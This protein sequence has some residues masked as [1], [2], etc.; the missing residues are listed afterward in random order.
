[1]K[2]KVAGVLS[3]LVLG[4]GLSTT[5]SATLIDRGNGMIYDTD[6]NLTWLQDANYAKTSG[7]DADG[8]MNWANSMTWASNLV[9]GG[10]D[11]WRLAGITD[12]GTSG[13]NYSTNGTDCGYNV[14][15]ANSELA[16]MYHVNLGLESYYNENGS[17]DPTFGIFGNGTYGGQNDVGLIDNLQSY[18]YW[19]GTEYAPYTNDA[20]FFSTDGGY[21]DDLNKGVE[22]YAWAVRSGDVAAQTQGTTVPEPGVLALMALGLVGMTAARWR[23]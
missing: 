10:Y 3:T 2:K 5:A 23:C 1:M 22:F 20:W 17:Y 15:T 7:Y 12:T 14:D 11:D 18:V 13:C 8:K 21:Q 16:Y 19:S 4:L 9:F 6:Q